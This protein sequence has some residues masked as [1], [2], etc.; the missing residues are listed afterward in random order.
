M[1]QIN[2]LPWREKSRKLKQNRFG[3]IALATA[4][5]GLF[6]TLLFHMDYSL[7]I[8][9][10]SKRNATL[11]AALDEESTHLKD[12]N[13]GKRELLDVDN[14][15][16]FIYSLRNT[17]YQAIQLLNKLAMINPDSITLSKIV[18]NGNTIL[19]TGKA[20]SNVQITL[21]MESIEQSKTFNQPVLTEISGKENETGEVRS[22]QLKLQQVE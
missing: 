12:L 1:T 13:K 4:G 11:Q 9:E 15:L 7:R 20:K 10:Q 2:L 5:M 21:F 16:H 19:I 17:G 3:L 22:F 14:Q 18:R 6:F 8:S